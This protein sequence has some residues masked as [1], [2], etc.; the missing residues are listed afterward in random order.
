MSQPDYPIFSKKHQRAQR[1]WRGGYNF[2]RSREYELAERWFEER[3]EA[4]QEKPPSPMV[5]SPPPSRPQQNIT[6][7]PP[8]GIS[9]P[10]NIKFCN[11]CKVPTSISVTVG[12][13]SSHYC[14][15]CITFETELYNK[16]YKCKSV[17]DASKY[18]E[19]DGC[20]LSIPSYDD[21]EYVEPKPVSQLVEI[22]LNNNP[23]ENIT[24]DYDRLMNDFQLYLQYTYFLG[25]YSLMY[26]Q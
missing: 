21:F 3:R 15:K 23:I 17:L 8:P 12:C 19:Y 20:D 18:E 26:K 6:K 22:P 1:S 5:Q 2:E 24:N 4:K 9:K 13:C 14:I 11:K 16:C 7:A 10:T 25:L